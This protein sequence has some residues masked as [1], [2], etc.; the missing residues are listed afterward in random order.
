MQWKLIALCIPIFLLGCER[1]SKDKAAIDMTL[2]AHG[3]PKLPS[4]AFN[5]EMFTAKHQRYDSIRIQFSCPAV[6][7]VPFIAGV[8]GAP[9]HDNEPPQS[10]VL[11]YL[12]TG[13]PYQVL[14]GRHIADEPHYKYVEA[15]RRAEDILDI[16]VEFEDIR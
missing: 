7:F 3:F 6:E 13:P 12:L 5:Q 15:R 9:A 16:S 14:K 8:P 11:N 1:Q 2:L 4:A 10:E